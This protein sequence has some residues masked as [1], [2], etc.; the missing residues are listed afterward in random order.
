MVTSKWLWPGILSSLIQ[1]PP[2]FETQHIY[3]STVKITFVTIMIWPYVLSKNILYVHWRT[4][5]LEKDSKGLHSNYLDTVFKE[6]RGGKESWVWGK[7]KS[8]GRG[9]LK[10]LPPSKVACAAASPPPFLRIE[11]RSA[12]PGPYTNS[13]NSN[14][15]VGA[16]PMELPHPWF[17][18]IPPYTA[19]M[20]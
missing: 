15:M 14:M 11:C 1:L 10:A 2:V 3:S 18:T 7:R 4:S 17:L 8:G 20:N 5:G 19:I 9:Q 6:W 12:S 13:I 16:C